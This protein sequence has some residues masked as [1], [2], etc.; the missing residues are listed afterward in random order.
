MTKILSIQV[1]QPSRRLVLLAVA[2]NP[3]TGAIEHQ[4]FPVL[5][6]ETRL[7]LHRGHD[8]DETESR[9]CPIVAGLLTDEPESIDVDDC[10]RLLPT[11]T[12][13]V[14]TTWPR[15][16][17]EA[18]LRPMIEAMATSARKAE[19]QRRARQCQKASRADDGRLARR[20]SI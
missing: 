19:Q 18:E 2:A 16:R 3:D 13:T 4:V 6:M 10:L 20:Q 11:I 14:V 12:R 9:H 15:E 1:W 8:E 7:L 5:A 17:D